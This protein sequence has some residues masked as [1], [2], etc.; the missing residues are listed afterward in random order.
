KNTTD[1][2]TSITFS[3]DVE[4]TFKSFGWKTF[5]I[6]NGDSDFCEIEA[7]L[8][9]AIDHK[10][11]PKLVIVNDTIGYGTEDAGTNK[12][13]SKISN[14]QYQK[15]KNSKK[16]G[17]TGKFQI[18]EDVLKV[19]KTASDRANLHHKKWQNLM[20]NYKKRFPKK[21]QKF[22]RI[23]KDKTKS[24][25]FET[26]FDNVLENAKVL[27][28]FENKPTRSISAAILELMA[29]FLPETIIGSADLAKSSGLILSLAKMNENLFSKENRSGRFI[30]FGVREHGF[31]KL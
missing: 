24:E 29:G 6:E 14:R 3:N 30:A 28:E 5:V 21:S 18:C 13:H 4:L 9:K 17:K 23:F 7:I 2:P 15:I 19:Y 20:Q 27:V 22:C 25:E 11:S 8:K 16:F 1:G 10:N 31:R 12:C 26:F